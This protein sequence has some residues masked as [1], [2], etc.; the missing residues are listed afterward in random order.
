MST[1]EPERDFIRVNKILGK[2]ASIGFI[3]ASQLLPWSVLVIVSYTL[4]NGIF[5]LGLAWFFVVSFWLITSWWILTG[6]KPHL[7]VDS[8][9]KPPGTEWCDGNS[10]YVSPLPSIRKVQLQARALQGK[11]SQ[12]R[13]KLK[14][15][16]VQSR[17]GKIHRFMPFQNETDLTCLV[18]IEKDGR[19][20]SGLLLT[21]EKGTKYQI[22][23]GFKTQG[24]HDLLFKSEVAETASS[25]EEGMKD[26]MPGEKMTF[27]LGCHSEDDE[28]QEELDRMADNC[29]LKPISVLIRNEQ[30]RVRELTRKGSRQIWDSAIFC[31]WTAD[32][33][34]QQASRDFISKMVDGITNLVNGLA[35]TKQYHEEQFY[36]RI[37]RKAFDEGFIPWEILLNTKMGLE[38]SPMNTEDTWKWLWKRFNKGVAPKVPQV[39]TLEETDRGFKIYEKRAT[40]KHSI[41]VL[42]K[43]DKG[44]SAC[45]EHHQSNDKV[46]IPGKNQVCGV[47]TMDEAPGGWANAR[48]QLRFIWK[49]LSNSYVHDTEA[50]VEVSVGNN[51]IISDNLEKQAKQSKTASTRA[52]TK[53]QGR[54]IGAE[55]KQEESFDAQ[56]RLYQGAKALNCG[57]AFLVYRTNSEDLQKS[58]NML[59]QAFGNAKV[60]RERNI[61]WEIWLQ[62]LPITM[63]WL[64]NS[65]ISLSERR[66]TLDTETVAGV[67]PLTI[68]RDIDSKGVEFIS[69]RGGKPLFVDLVDDQISRALIVGESGSG[70]SVL[71]WRFALQALAK[72]IPVVGIDISSGGNSTFKTAIEILGDCAG[73]F[74]LSKG[75][76]NLM[77]PPDLR[78]FDKKEKERRLEFWKEFVRKALTVIAM[79][80]IDHPHLTQRVDSII[81]KMLD[82]YLKDP[83]IIDR[84]N[85]GFEKGWKS[86][87]WQ[88]MPTLHDLLRFCSRERL[89][90]RS[91]E[92]LDR[93]AISQIN[94]QVE[95]LLAS[96]IGKAIGRPSTFSPEPAI[97]F[98]AL[99]GL[100]N[101]QDSY[102]M[103]INAHM[104]CIR[105]ALSH[106][107]SLFIGDELSVILKKPGFANL[108]GELAATGRKEGIGL[109]LISQD[110]DAICNC[111]AGAQIMQ[112]LVCRITGRITNAGVASA[113]RYLNYDP[114]IVAKNATDAF[115]PRKSDL[116]SCWL[117]EKGGRF[118]QT[119]FY[120]G[121]MLLGS[122]ANNQAEKEA[123]ERIMAKYPKTMKGQL[124]GLKDFSFEYIR[125]IKEGNSLSTIGQNIETFSSS[126]V[127]DSANHEAGVASRGVGSRE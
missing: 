9:R 59:S 103:A 23:F 29:N 82:F 39:L 8:F 127:H 46:Y 41:T 61:A 113:Q 90:L 57:V 53:G 89:N 71:A 97:K 122:V 107:R 98:F 30:V 21:N 48:E 51:F 54:D 12:T 63:K 74:D 24:L 34:G 38:I 68:P 42:I 102:L 37:L 15:V 100:T 20:I 93:M 101:E 86:D 65:G 78:N 26:L 70:K 7:F 36:I 67:L 77:E 52:V 120:P 96:R 99:S 83:E 111:P 123:R 106:P 119:R 13:I 33:E 62:T 114:S 109:L 27:Y 17:K 88:Q 81:L 116:Y 69:A 19:K 14:P 117:I 10:L 56:K 112:N 85:A 87:E 11:N 3:P 118:W 60:I 47:L 5:S 18:E 72:N 40:E 2:Q 58:C 110:F 50:W 105:N 66:L 94:N 124:M 64:L 76:S 43:G 104:A 32:N 84:Y 115:E 75:A 25:I 95:A 126:D 4:T 121:E 44:L 55:I 16:I 79:G 35:G 73:Y 22:V 125:A 80:K 31:T 1:R 91:Y 6:N 92:E 49:T 45:P 28:K 108:I